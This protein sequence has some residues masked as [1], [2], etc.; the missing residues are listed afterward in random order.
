MDSKLVGYILIT[1]SKLKF[2]IDSS[3]K[4]QITLIEANMLI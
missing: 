3:I 4:S 1:D 2:F